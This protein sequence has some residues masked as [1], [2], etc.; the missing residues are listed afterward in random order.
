VGQET[1]SHTRTIIG[2]DIGGSKIT[3]VQGTADAQILERRELPTLPHLPFADDWPGLS[4]LIDFLKRH[5]SLAGRLWPSVCLLVGHYGFRREFF[6][7]LRTCL[8]GTTYGS[9]IGWRKPF[10]GFPSLSSMTATQVPWRNFT[11]E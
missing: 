2:V 11:L 5:R 4:R 1:G 3:V 7:T 9:R 8:A 10:P 6:P